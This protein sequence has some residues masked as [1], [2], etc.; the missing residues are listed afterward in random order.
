M[1][2]R[3]RCL[4]CGAE[5]GAPPGNVWCPSDEGCLQYDCHEEQVPLFEALGKGRPVATHHEIEW[6]NYGDFEEER[7]AS[8][9]PEPDHSP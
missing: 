5:W 1:L 7:N 2:A 3:F 4:V 8:K 6:L 9:R